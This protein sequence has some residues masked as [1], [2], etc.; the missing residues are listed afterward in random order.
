MSAPRFVERCCP[1]SDYLSR[2]KEKRR[3]VAIAPEIAPTNQEAFRPVAARPQAPRIFDFSSSVVDEDSNLDPADIA[4]HIEGGLNENQE[5]LGNSDSLHRGMYSTG[6]VPETT[7][8]ETFI[9]GP[10]R[11]TIESK[12]LW[13]NQQ[14]HERD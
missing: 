5:W 13:G 14:I 3:T 10:K 8:K 7:S 11:G 12:W 6:L 1:I 9:D 4:C 2:D